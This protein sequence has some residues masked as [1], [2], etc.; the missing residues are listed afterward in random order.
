LHC[1]F[2]VLLHIR[3]FHHVRMCFFLPQCTACQKTDSGY[4]LALRGQFDK[5]VFQFVKLF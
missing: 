3:V 1:K 5:A 2:L 4:F